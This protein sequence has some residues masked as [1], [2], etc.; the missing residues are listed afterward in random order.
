MTEIVLFQYMCVCGIYVVLNYTFRLGICG[1]LNY[2]FFSFSLF[3][4]RKI[5]LCISL[6]TA[7]SCNV[8]ETEVI[9][10]YTSSP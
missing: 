4:K 6:L 10:A 1:V 2:T 5:Y 9:L 8:T 3:L 7:V